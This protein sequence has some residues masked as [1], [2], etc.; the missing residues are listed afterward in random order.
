MKIPDTHDVTV[1]DAQQLA[2][3]LIL[4]TLDCSGTPVAGTH[5]KPGQ[6]TFLKR[7]DDDAKPFALANAPAGDRLEILVRE[8][9]TPA[10]WL[11]AQTR[12]AVQLAPIGGPGYP[13]DELVGRDVLL[14]AMGSAIAPIRAALQAICR[15][16]DDFGAVKLIYGERDAERM[17]FREDLEAFRQA[18]VDVQVVLSQPKAVDA[19]TKGYVQDHLPDTFSGDQSVLLC[20][21]PAMERACVAALNAAG[22]DSAH[23]H[24][25]F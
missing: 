9:D 7:G 15:R 11:K 5:T 10:S 13:L 25:N 20:G 6:Y 8:K 19:P 3:D 24:R 23:I 16:R 21:A 2:S 22:V 14:L 12:G 17:A 18:N 4:L 1:L